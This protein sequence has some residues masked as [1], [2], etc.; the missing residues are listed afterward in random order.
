MFA[1]MSALDLGRLRMSVG[2]GGNKL[3][4]PLSPIEVGQLLCA[5]QNKGI[6]LEDCAREIQLDGTN[7]KRFIKILELP[8]DIKHLVNWGSSKETISFSSAVELLRLSNTD[9]QRAVANRILEDGFTRNEIRQ[10][11]Q[12]RNRS[13]RSIEDCIA[14]VIGMRPIVEKCYIFLGCISDSKLINA[15]AKLTQKERDGILNSKIE[16]FELRNVKGRL[17][18][19]FFTLVGDQQLDSKINSLGKNSFENL[20]R[21]HISEAVNS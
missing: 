14:E 18:Q 7:I 5:A 11:V 20:I 13:K 12:L 2:Y 6:T 19:Q 10:I 3:H 4:R 17:G 9:E 1:E 16:K 15:L 8:N 21:Q